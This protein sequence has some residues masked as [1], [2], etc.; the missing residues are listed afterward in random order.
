[1]VRSLISAKT[2]QS[3]LT[4][5]QHQSNLSAQTH[6]ERARLNGDMV[7]K[8]PDSDVSCLLRFPFDPHG[9]PKLLRRSPHAGCDKRSWILHAD[10]DAMPVTSHKCALPS[11][12]ISCTGFS[13]FPSLV[14]TCRNSI[15]LITAAIL[16]TVARRW[17]PCSVS[18]FPHGMVPNPNPKEET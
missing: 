8:Q 16:Q 18:H 1:M 2:Y 5:K 10:D 4:T 12:F 3:W 13:Y 9:A 11:F 15:S 14:E 17:S 7:D 6:R